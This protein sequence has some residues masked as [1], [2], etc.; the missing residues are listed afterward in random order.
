MI[1]S[2]TRTYNSKNTS[3]LRRNSKTTTNK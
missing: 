2:C 1:H 3:L